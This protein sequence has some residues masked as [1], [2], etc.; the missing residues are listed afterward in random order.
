MGIQQNKT[1]ILKKR[2]NEKITTGFLKQ[3]ARL[4]KKKKGSKACFITTVPS[5][6]CFLKRSKKINSF[7]NTFFTGMLSNYSVTYKYGFKKSQFML[8]GTPTVLILIDCLEKSI[9]KEAQLKNIP[10]IYIGS[11]NLKTAN[12]TYQIYT[13]N[14]KETIATLDQIIKLL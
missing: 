2:N 10:I 12:F 3:V 4:I 7:I 9:L 6:F 11:K 5:I 14:L 13:L 1:E 8:K